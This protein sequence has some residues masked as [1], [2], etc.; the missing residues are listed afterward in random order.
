M[1]EMYPRNL[2]KAKGNASYMSSWFTMSDVRTQCDGP[3]SSS[4]THKSYFSLDLSF[5]VEVQGQWYLFINSHSEYCPGNNH[6]VFLPLTFNFI[7]KAG[8]EWSG[9]KLR[10]T[11][12]THCLDLNTR[13]CT[14]NLLHLVY[15]LRILLYY[16]Q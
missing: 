4:F 16:G 12:S 7:P 15:F 6:L 13:L 1:L 14:N 11:H 2:R 9:N 8:R 10:I 5:K 3:S